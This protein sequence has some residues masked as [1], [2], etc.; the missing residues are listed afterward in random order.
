MTGV[1]DTNGVVFLKRIIFIFIHQDLCR[2]YLFVNWIKHGVVQII[3]M[4]QMPAQGREMQLSVQIDPRQ[5]CGVS[6]LDDGNRVGKIPGSYHQS[7]NMKIQYAVA[8][9]EETRCSLH[10]GKRSVQTALYG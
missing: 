6:P 1:K 10:L 8:R 4:G 3:G 2:E 7:P 9:V 5:T